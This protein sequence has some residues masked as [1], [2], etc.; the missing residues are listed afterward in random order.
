MAE[1]DVLLFPSL[2]EGMPNVLVEALALGLPVVASRV[3][4]NQDVVKDS[5]CVVWADPASPADVARQIDAVLNGEIDLGE[6]IRKG[7]QL[8]QCFGPHGMVAQYAEAYA[9][10]AKETR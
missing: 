7:R 3:V 6:N 10:L 9:S 4:A 8:A 5:E 1:A 2:Y